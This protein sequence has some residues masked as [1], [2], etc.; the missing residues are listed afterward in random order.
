LHTTDQP[1]DLEAVINCLDTAIEAAC[2]DTLEPH[3]N[4]HPHRVFWWNDD[5]IQAQAETHTAQLGSAQKAATRTLKQTITEAKQKWAHKK[6]HQ[7][8][9]VQDIWSLTKLQKG[10]Q[11]NMFPPLH[12][13]DNTLVNNLACKVQIFQD[14]FFPTNP[15][16]VQTKQEDDP[17]PM[18]LH[19]WAEITLEEISN[20]LKTASNSSV[21]GPSRIGYC[22]LK[23][24]HTVEPTTLTHIFNLSLFTGHHSWKHAMVMILNKPNKLDYSLTKAYHPISLLECTTKLLEKIVA[25]RVNTDIISSNLLSMSQFGSCLHHNAINAVATLIYCI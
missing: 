24:A 20:T 13:T 12:D 11:A 25:K 17:P 15:T 2:K 10:W 6:L 22:L 19:I 1:D 21:L 8:V 16:A 5:C 9:N 23:W 4:P 3:H 7:A 14:K 18:L